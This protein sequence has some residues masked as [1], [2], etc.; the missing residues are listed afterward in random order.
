MS[1][2]PDSQV[3][4]KCLRDQLAV[5]QTQLEELR[6]QFLPTPPS[7]QPLTLPSNEPEIP[8]SKDPKLTEPPDFD[9][10]PHEYVTFF[11]LITQ[12]LEQKP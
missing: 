3:E 7:G 4:N 5:F 11:S 1:T 8:A 10:N 12:Y 9:G 2:S 6:S